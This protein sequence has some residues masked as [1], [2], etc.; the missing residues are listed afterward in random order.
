MEKTFNNQISKEKKIM[1]YNAMID[2]LDE[3]MSN[4][5]DLD[6]YEEFLLVKRQLMAKLL[7]LEDVSQ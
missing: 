6:E 2:D 7:N 3:K 5:K 4:S 1:F